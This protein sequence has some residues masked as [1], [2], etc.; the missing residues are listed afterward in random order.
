MNTDRYTKIILTLIAVGLVLNAASNFTSPAHAFGSGQDVK[1]T[2]LE[3]DIRR[4]EM[5]LELCPD[6]INSGDILNVHC[7]YCD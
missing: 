6:C 2:N 3:T 4:G 5:L 1:V 7:M